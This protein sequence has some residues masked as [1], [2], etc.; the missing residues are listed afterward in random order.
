MARPQ[1]N[2]DFSEFN[3]TD[4]MDVDNAPTSQGSTQTAGSGRSIFSSA[5]PAIS[6]EDVLPSI[7]RAKTQPPTPGLDSQ[8]EG[9][10]LAIQNLFSQSIFKSEDREM[11][12][13]NP[14]NDTPHASTPHNTSD[15]EIA[16][17]E[18][19]YSPDLFISES[20]GEGEGVPMAASP[21][22]RRSATTQEHPRPSASIFGGAVGGPVATPSIF[23][24]PVQA[25]KSIPKQTYNPAHLLRDD[26][27][28][29]KPAQFV[30]NPPENDSDDDCMIIE[31]GDASTEAKH[32][33]NKPSKGKKVA[34]DDDE[35][36]FV[37]EEPINHAVLPSPAPAVQLPSPPPAPKKP[38]SAFAVAKILAAQ[39]AMFRSVRAQSNGEGPSRAQIRGHHAQP[40]SSRGF[41]RFKDSTFGRHDPPQVQADEDDAW[42]I[43]E[44]GVDYEFEKMT[45]L[46]DLLARRERKGNLT[47]EE[48]LEL[49]KIRKRL[50]TKERL[51]AAAAS[52]DDEEKSLLL[53]A[54][55]RE[56]TVRRHRRDRPCQAESEDVES[57][58]EDD[59][60]G[61]YDDRDE[62]VRMM[63]ELDGRDAEEE[64]LGLTKSGKPRKRRVRPANGIAQSRP[65]DAREYAA[66]EK[67]K[68]RSKA[69]KK[70]ARQPAALVTASSSRR[71]TAPAAAKG[72]G[73]G[74]GREK[75]KEKA[76]NRTAKDK[77]KGK[78]KGKDVIKNGPSLISSAGGFARRNGEDKIGQMI[79][80]D[81][82]SNDPISERLQ[83]PVFNRPAE[84]TISGPQV[85]NTQFQLL[86]ANIP[87]PESNIER[88]AIKTDKAKLREAS[89]SFGYAK[90]KAHDGKWLIKGMKSP[91]YHH[92]LLGAQWMV[93]RELSSQ[94]PHGG[95]L[96]DSMGLGKTVQTLACMVGNP[97][98]PEDIQRK[99][100]TTLIVVPATVIEQWIDEIRLHVDKRIFPKV[101]HYKTSSK[102]DID[103]LQDIDIVVTSYN[104]VMKQFPFPDTEG[105]LVI[106][107]HGYKKWWKRAIENM[108]V[109]HQI[110]WYRVV[111]DEAQAI[112]NNS[113]RT[114]LAC[115]NL[116]SVYRWC[117]TGTPLLN[118]L[119]ELFPYLRF[120]KANYSMDWQTFQKYF[121]DPMAANSYSRIST[122]LSYTMMRRTMK[123]TILNRPIITLPPPH[124]NIQ[125]INFSPEE[126]IIYRITENR[127][128]SN[129]NSFFKK[130]EAS[131]N[132]GVFM[133]QLLRLRQ[134]TSHPFMLER[135]IKESWTTEDLHELQSGL[136]K[137][138]NNARPF[139]EQ[140]KVW[141]EQSEAR[142]NE[143]R[144]RGEDVPDD[145]MLPFGRSD[146]GREF[147][148]EKVLKTLNEQEL[149]GRVTC[150]ICSDLP[151]DP[152]QTDCG[153][154]FCKDCLDSFCHQLVAG[155]QEFMTCPECN[156][157]FQ[158]TTPVQQPP[159]DVY[160]DSF[161]GSGSR[162][163][164]NGK[165][166][167]KWKENPTSKGRDLFGFEPCTKDSS[168]VTKSDTD[169]DFP[170]TAS[171]KTTALKALLLKGFEEAPLDKVVIYVQF[172]T[173]ARI[174]GRICESEGWGFLYL[175]GDSS[176]EHRTRAIKHFR[177]ND[178][179][180]ILIA[181]L[182][183]GGL[184]LNFP[185]ANRCI[186][187]DLWW[188]HAVEQQAFGRIFRIGQL[189]ETYM[190]RLV[191]KNSVDMRMLSM[192]L[193][194]LRNLERAMRDG[195]SKATPN[196]SMKQ[197]SNLFGFLKTDG[198]G[199][200]VSVEADYED[201]EEGEGEGGG[202]GGGGG[203]GS[204]RGSGG[205]QGAGAGA[206]GDGDGDGNGNG[207]GGMSN[208]NGARKGASWEGENWENNGGS[209]PEEELSSWNDVSMEG[210]GRRAP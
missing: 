49:F 157:V 3:Q 141:V 67:E 32:K 38:A 203:S 170:L 102:L 41:D 172:R 65:K 82:M 27:H 156:R 43:E 190:T 24:G 6:Q 53:P 207:A 120:L 84:A 161:S 81:L 58:I 146:Y 51:R 171:S 208:N 56:Q 45:R 20:K 18:R 73:R 87:E 192:Q 16:D 152:T 160:D 176:L 108:G 34:R 106:A 164:G 100:K 159:D 173:L 64:D 125:Y 189:K 165:E 59:A 85:K 196:L 104:E 155:E 74:K 94:P 50:E 23:G 112:K 158:R 48:S 183:C 121:C 178:E 132:Y 151:I 63:A 197:L 9:R 78:G 92:Q 163:N 36:V 166:K 148:M 22:S 150:S 14:G 75:D 188:N 186:S 47:Q 168:W 195:E 198:D 137:L 114:S 42:M 66:R 200:I 126:Q 101:L 88:G 118:R 107:K 202:G 117:L 91:L 79:L 25:P 122:V 95:L 201:G 7:E 149:Y 169:P 109:L 30:V 131:R 2:E 60:E 26:D 17:G 19:Q 134:C 71:K 93:Q 1:I 39:Q 142:R 135:T 204:Y 113:A 209:N 205:S 57:N 5:S 138:K 194:K 4:E 12:G 62:I 28:A 80:E 182:K 184:G 33:W 70:R 153:H 119:E 187:L 90:C 199:R 185:W 10:P 180:K 174:V 145:E 40:L 136:G 31:E 89:R 147:N 167:G 86:F 21:I 37:K 55:T 133:V 175:T 144:D 15:I 61:A 128:R 116:K 191:V 210:Y 115:Q 123:T 68:E 127:F 124:P 206:I 143:R 103:I 54:E 177:D 105:R 181:G 98:G 129:L 77:S 111:L 8:S 96:A 179:A 139:Y 193:H 13:I 97:P 35:V 110:N 154:I 29:A 76:A 162:G 99:V 72:R 130:G 52:R 46:E 11:S 83:N 69:Q 44:D 140:C